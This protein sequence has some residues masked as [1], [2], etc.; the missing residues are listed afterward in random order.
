[1]SFDNQVK[2]IKNNTLDKFKKEIQKLE[3]KNLE[4]VANSIGKILY[5][6][7]TNMVGSYQRHT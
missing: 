1:M 7:F 6:L 4:D 3:M 5:A 2:V